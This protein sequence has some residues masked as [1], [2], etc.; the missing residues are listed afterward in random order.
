MLLGI[1]ITALNGQVGSVFIG[2]S[3]LRLEVDDQRVNIVPGS[4]TKNTSIPGYSVGWL[5][6]QIIRHKSVNLETGLIF[7][8]MGGQWS[9]Q[10]PD[11]QPYTQNLNFH[12]IQIPIN[13]R[14]NLFHADGVGK[15]GGVPI[16]LLGGFRGGVSII[17][18]E[19]ITQNGLTKTENINFGNEPSQ[20]RLYDLGVRGGVA[21]KLHSNWSIEAIVYRGLQDFVN[22]DEK[23]ALH[24]SLE[25]RLRFH[26]GSMDGDRRYFF[27]QYFRSDNFW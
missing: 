24:R 7:S 4:I 9:Y 3:D 1:S 11:Q 14:I 17:G 6:N 23:S 20:Y 25:F 10:L 12:Q 19:T 13:F 21:L 5:Y 8:R 22:L 18:E 15:T 27:H 16:Y 26:F 2:Y